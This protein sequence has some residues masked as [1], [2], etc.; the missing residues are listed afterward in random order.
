MPAV[1]SISLGNIFF[2]KQADCSLRNGLCAT[3]NDLSSVVCSSRYGCIFFAVNSSL[4]IENISH[5]E[6]LFSSD[7]TSIDI[8]KC[9]KVLSG[10][11]TYLSLSPSELYIAVSLLQRIEVYCTQDLNRNVNT[12]DFYM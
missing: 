4:C 10:V 2:V 9:C 5:I 6:D 3:Q 11:I 7:D 12:V 1:T 8:N